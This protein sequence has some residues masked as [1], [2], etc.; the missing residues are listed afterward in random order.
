[1]KN[2]GT[3][4]VLIHWW[5]TLLFLLSNRNRNREGNRFNLAMIWQTTVRIR[6]TIYTR[7]NTDSVLWM[8]R[9]DTMEMDIVWNNYCTVDSKKNSSVE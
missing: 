9:Y 2:L 7:D 6:N 8:V 4:R 3:V 5:E 1:M